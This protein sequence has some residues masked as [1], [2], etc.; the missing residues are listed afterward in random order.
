MFQLVILPVDES[1]EPDQSIRTE[2]PYTVD[3]SRTFV[4]GVYQSRTEIESVRQSLENPT[5]MWPNREQNPNNE[6]SMEG[7]FSF[8]F[9]TLFPTGAAEF[10]APQIHKLTIGNYFKHLVMYDDRRFAKHCRFWYFALNTEMRWCALQTGR[11][12]V[13]QNPEDA[14]LSVDELRDMVGH[15]G[16]NFSS[17]VLYFASSLQG[18]RQYWMQQRRRLIAMVDAIGTPTIFFY[19][20]CCRFSV[21]WF[22]QPILLPR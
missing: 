1:D 3:L 2:D 10:L 6:F 11:I 18:T 14:H 5:V 20:Q 8:A 7:Y 17:C 15:D 13:H 12:Y 16:E 4:P 9:L 19:P 22:R 21:A